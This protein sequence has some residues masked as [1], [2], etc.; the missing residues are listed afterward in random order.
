MKPK[1]FDFVR[2]ESL[3][4]A[5]AVLAE[6]G[7]DARILAGGQSQ[8]AMLN[9]RLIETKLLID[10]V[11][12]DEL[13]YIRVDNGAL[14]VGA[15][16]RQADLK[17]WPELA[18]TVPLLHAA[19][20]H[21]GH[22]QTRNQGT[23]C[24]SIAHSDPSSEL[25]LCLA[26]LEGEVVLQSQ[27]GRRTVKAGDF[28]VDLLTTAKRSDEMITAVRF[29]LKAPGTGYAFDEM[30][31]RRG[32]FAIVS[33]AAAASENSVRLGV[34]GV[35]ATPT[36]RDWPGL[37]DAGL[38]DALNAFAWDL[39]GGDDIHASGQYRRELV[40]R[41]GRRTIMEAKKCRS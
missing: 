12:I 38:D 40:R 19:L 28:Q 8:V 18:E 41:L 37:D 15:A 24:G 27:G 9:F 1:Q 13:N 31:R 33:L 20:P 35:A 14:E 7:E 16:T 36:V 11:R 25:P 34:G 17:D 2:A 4:E 30:N 6:H 29:P 39:G 21:L 23:V 32:D 26:T 3:G 5:L 10:I 22:F